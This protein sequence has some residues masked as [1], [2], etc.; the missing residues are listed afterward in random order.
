M[1]FT[2]PGL[3]LL[4]QADDLMSRRGRCKKGVIWV[5]TENEMYYTLCFPRWSGYFKYF[6]L[7]DVMSD[8]M[9]EMLRIF[10]KKS[11]D[12]G[13]GGRPMHQILCRMGAE[14]REEG[15]LYIYMFPYP[16]AESINPFDL[17]NKCDKEWAF[18]TN[19]SICLM[20]EIVVIYGHW[21]ETGLVMGFRSNDD[22]VKYSRTPVWMG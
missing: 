3:L 21:F 22:I 4:R 18:K 17:M 12:V 19:H 13:G 5:G 2:E 10:G 15:N 6:L 16:K 20:D 1:Q 9:V 14:V 7:P 11:S 8:E